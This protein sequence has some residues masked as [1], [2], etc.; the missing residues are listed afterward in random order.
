MQLRI[1]GLTSLAMACLFLIVSFSG[2]ILY[3]TPQGRVANWTNWTLL[4]LG[5]HDWSAVH[6]NACFNR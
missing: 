3:M 5:K 6:I 2:I 1:K 4:G